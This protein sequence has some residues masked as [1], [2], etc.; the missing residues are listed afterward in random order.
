MWWGMT[1]QFILFHC[2]SGYI[3]E[4]RFASLRIYLVWCIRSSALKSVPLRCDRGEGGVVW[5]LRRQFSQFA[6][7]PVPEMQE[8]YGGWCF[9]QPVKLCFLEPSFR[10]TTFLYFRHFLRHQS[11][12]NRSPNAFWC[13]S[14][15][16]IAVYFP[17]ELTHLRPPIR[18]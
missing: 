1:P 8:S 3:Q 15:S 2:I 14:A 18:C 9:N 4:I 11:V 16:I 13:F 6:N 5:G 17:L 7:I 12:V 10:E